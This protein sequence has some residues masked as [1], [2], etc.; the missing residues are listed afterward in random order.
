[1]VVQRTLLHLVL[2]RALGRTRRNLLVGQP[3]LLF[4]SQ[5]ETRNAAF[6]QKRIQGTVVWVYFCWPE[7]EV[8]LPVVRMTSL[9]LSCS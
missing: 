6:F 9:E 5:L 8:P 4:H 1:M 3:C 7:V 2:T